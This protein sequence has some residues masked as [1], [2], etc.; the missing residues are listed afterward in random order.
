M[1]SAEV[2]LALSALAQQTRLDV[3]QRL[4][5]HEPDGIAAGELARLAAVPQNTMSSHLAILQR[6]GLITATRHS[7]SIVY[8]ANLPAF[9]AVALFLLQ[10]CCGGR[11]EVCAPLIASLTPCCTPTKTSRRQGERS[12]QKRPVDVGI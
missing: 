3:F 7:R 8:R 11:A 1:E 10:D 9:Q 6:A 12:R 5:R 2:I 4:V